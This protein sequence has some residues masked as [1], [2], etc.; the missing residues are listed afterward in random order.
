MPETKAHTQEPGGPKEPFPPFQVQT[1]PSQLFWL[2]V[3][4]VALY[5]LMAKVALPRIA[6]ILEARR[7]RI[8]DDLSTAET[9]KQQSAAALEAYEK[10]LADARNRAHSIALDTRAQLM[11]E[12]DA[13][14]RALEDKLN[15]QLTEAEKVIAATKSAAM[16]NVHAIAVDAAA[17]IVEHLI[18]TTPS[19]K[20][21]D[22]AVDEVLKR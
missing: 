7:A 1:F 18:G 8:A 6:A 11:A 10:A 20:S 16:A 14:R 13:R 17:A 9:L 19:A 3:T 4:F 15:A 12:A 21:I 5:L 2:A 22:K